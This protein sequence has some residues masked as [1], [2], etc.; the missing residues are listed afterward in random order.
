M[1]LRRTP[2]RSSQGSTESHPTDLNSAAEESAVALVITLLM[3]SVITFLAI[4][5]LAM[6]KRNRS[7]VT[8][9]LDVANSKTM[10][11]AALAR[12]QAQIIAQ[13]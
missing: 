7:A 12:A 6:S 9:T 5:F 4:A 2:Y 11:D 3:L 13:M 10:A 1:R 8:T